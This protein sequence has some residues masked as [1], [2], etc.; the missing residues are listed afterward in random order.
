VTVDVFAR[1]R[2]A[3]N[4]LAVFLDADGLKTDEMQ[5]LAREMNYSETAFVL[6]PADPG[7]TAKV[8]IFHRTA[9]MAFAGHPN[10]GTAF[11]L[12]RHR[13]LAVEDCL[14]FEQMAGLVR[15]RLRGRGGAISGA[16]I[17]APQALHTGPTFDCALI[18]AC[19]SLSPDQI[20]TTNHLPVEASVGVTFVI[21]EVTA[22]ALATAAPN[23]DAFE[24]LSRMQPTESGRLS[25]FIYC[26]LSPSTPGARS[27]SNVRARMFAPLAGTWEDPATGSANAIL[28]ALKLSHTDAA[29]LSY[30]AV[31]GVEMGRPSHLHL[32]ARRGSDGIRAQVG[33]DCV[34]VFRGKIEV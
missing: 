11:V 5:I 27:Q 29:S 6:T 18:A 16:E 30:E 15:V 8:R 7:H 17:D 25:L 33:G 12:A 4:P 34:E 31:Q 3:G 23:L 20:I 22:E 2:F 1:E 26:D 10:I 9:E 24:E 32:S 14:Q 28:A 13:G 21:V 19:V